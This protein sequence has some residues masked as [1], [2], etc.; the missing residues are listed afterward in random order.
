MSDPIKGNPVTYL[1]SGVDEE[2]PFEI[3][4]RYNDF[5]NFY[6]T[7]LFRWPGIYIPP[8]PPKKAGVNK[9]EK[10]L[11][12]RKIFLEKFIRVLGENE[13]LVH[14]EEF[15]VFSRHNG[16]IEKVFKVLPRLTPDILL[17][18]FE[19]CLKYT[20]A[21]DSS[22]TKNWITEINEFSSFSKKAQN[23]L[24]ELREK[25]KEMANTKELLNNHYLNLTK[26]LANYEDTNLKEYC[27]DVQSRY[28]F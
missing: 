12:E 5:Y 23:M 26:L 28:S 4:R 17:K 13:F 16:N 22:Q 14:S 19:S 1:V 18:R 24:K 10:N 9:D 3:S 7:L 20:E 8:I 2:G 21:P 11:K 6:K 27:E 15:K 25:T